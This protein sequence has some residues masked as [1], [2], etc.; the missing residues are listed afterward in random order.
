MKKTLLILG[1]FLIFA[2]FISGFVLSRKK[3]VPSQVMTSPTPAMMVST[4]LEE[5]P[6]ISLIPSEDG[7]WLNLLV[8]R[9]QDADS[10]EYELTYITTDGLTQGAVGGPFK[11]EGKTSY[12]KRILLGTESS[13][14]YRYYEGIET[15]NLTIRLYGGKGTRKFTSD[16]HLQKET[17]QLSAI[18]GQFKAKIA[19]IKGQFYVVM[20]TIG[21]PERID[22][23]VNAGPFGIFS[24]G[25][26]KIKETQVELEGGT[27]IFFWTGEKWQSLINNTASGI[28]TFVSLK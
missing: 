3:N 16:F 5:R 22:G 2:I 23:E 26:S 21:L 7:H 6:F 1:I 4:T 14:H 8:S 18:N 10:M 20:S 11:L 27:N 17:D 19:L 28:G 13:G 25:K 12:E 24:S 9:I 15:G